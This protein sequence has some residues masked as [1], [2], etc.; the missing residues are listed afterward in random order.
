MEKLGRGVTYWH[1]TGAYTGDDMHVLCVCLSKY[2]IEELLHA[3]HSIDPHAFSR[4]RRGFG[5]TET[6]R[7]RWAREMWEAEWTAVLA[8]TPVDSRMGVRVLLECGLED[9]AFPGGGPL[10]ADGVPAL[11]PG[12]EDPP[13]CCS[14]LEGVREQG[15]RRV[16]VYASPSS[17]AVEF[18]AFGR[19]D[20]AA[21]CNR[22][23]RST[24]IWR[25]ASGGWG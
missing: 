3:V 13:R 7:E 5:F 12:G 11:H 16:L 15:C 22:R 2:E 8:G 1:G 4:C 19:G 25:L 18:D 9:G 17:A 14:V 6:I 23:C 21:D 24:G 20:R 10:A